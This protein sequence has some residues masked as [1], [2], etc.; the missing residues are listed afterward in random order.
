MSRWVAQCYNPMVRRVGCCL[1]PCRADPLR[2]RE[3]RLRPPTRPSLPSCAT[4]FPAVFY[5]PPL[6]GSGLGMFGDPPELVVLRLR[7]PRSPCRLPESVPAQSS[8]I[9]QPSFV[10]ARPRPLLLDLAR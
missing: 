3:T 5:E 2:P 8:W 9:R 10:L 7:C 4:V 6:Q 1:R